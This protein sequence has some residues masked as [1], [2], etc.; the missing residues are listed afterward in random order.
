MRIL[1]ATL[2]LAFLLSGLSV[3]GSKETLPGIGTFV[4]NGSPLASAE[5]MVLADNR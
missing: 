1:G 4:Y 5:M 2:V 3:A